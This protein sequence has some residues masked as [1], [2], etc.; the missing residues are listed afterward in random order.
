MLNYSFLAIEVWFNFVINKLCKSKMKYSKWGFV[1]CFLIIQ[2]S[3]SWGGVFQGGGSSELPLT[4]LSLVLSPAGLGSGGQPLA[5]SP[6]CSGS[7]WRPATKGSI[8]WDLPLSLRLC[9]PPWMPK[10]GMNACIYVYVPVHI[11]VW[12]WV[13]CVH[14]LVQV[15]ANTCA[16]YYAHATHVWVHMY[17][18]ACECTWAGNVCMCA[19][20]C[21]SVHIHEHPH[22]CTHVWVGYICVCT[23]TCTCTACMCAHTQ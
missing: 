19:C 3:M 4:S 15:H 16:Y 17:I 21:G 6:L 10:L 5:P 22:V 18:F 14:T 20:G 11:Y 2:Y 8:V 9:G 13:L 1:K 23:C 7:L 12:M